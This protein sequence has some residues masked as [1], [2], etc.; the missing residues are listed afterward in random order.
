MYTKFENLD[1]DKQDRILNA[2]MHEFARNGFERA[3]TNEIVKE[4]DISKGLLFHYFTSKK[5][6]Y[7][8]L[9]DHSI[10]QFM[11]EFFAKLNMDD[12][13]FF[14]RLHQSIHLKL[15][16][17]HQYPSLF[18]FFESTMMEDSNEIRHELEAKKKELIDIGF[19]KIFAG[20]DLTKFKEGADMN[21]VLNI[22]LWTFERFGKEQMEKA[23]KQSIPLDYENLY[24]EIDDY[25]EL[26]KQSFY[27]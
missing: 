25:I 14:S 16:I 3:S 10:E 22:I 7:L 6:L 21:K 17:Q 13:D 4:A 23:R 2:A 1:S 11:N 8:Y 5:Y 12:H 19:A 27:K 24:A 20:V 18:Q 15:N 26:F 9:Y